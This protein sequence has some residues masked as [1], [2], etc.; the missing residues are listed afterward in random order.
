[1]V[2]RKYL[3]YLIL[4]K[5][6]FVHTKNRRIYSISPSLSQLS[7]FKIPENTLFMHAKHKNS[8]KN[9]S[10]SRNNLTLHEDPPDDNY[11]QNDNY[12][13]DNNDTHDDN[14]THDNNDA[15][16]NNADSNNDTYNNND[17]DDDKKE[18]DNTFINETQ[19]QRDEPENYNRSDE[20]EN[21]GDLKNTFVDDFNQN[22]DT[23]MKEDSR[24]NNSLANE[25]EP[26]KAQ[27]HPDDNK[28]IV[29]D[30]AKE[31][32]MK[33][34]NTDA[35]DMI[36]SAKQAKEH[37]DELL[38]QYKEGEFNTE[39]NKHT[40]PKD[41]AGN[42]IITNTTTT[43]MT[44]QEEKAD[45]LK[46][47]RDATISLYERARH[48]NLPVP[49]P[50]DLSSPEKI[51]TS[52]NA[53]E[54]II[55]GYRYTKIDV[56]DKTEQ[57]DSLNENSQ[58]AE[59]KEPEQMDESEVDLMEPD[60]FLQLKKSSDDDDEPDSEQNDDNEDDFHTTEYDNEMNESDNEMNGSDEESYESDNGMNESDEESY[61][62]ES[63]KSK[64]GTISAHEAMED[65]RAV[66]N[67]LS[68]VLEKVVQDNIGVRHV[69][70]KQIITSQY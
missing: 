6:V 2:K 65:L 54:Y 62:S 53:L 51:Y 48:K 32:Q 64:G 23:N 29:N 24:E 67:Q 35:G 56:N 8:I 49:D 28:E 43:P 33:N 13:H 4:L 34:M 19:N 12:T 9:S 58:P 55:D 52:L 3:L 37:A 59:T 10:R 1:M 61:E 11:Q 63:E 42:I 20:P 68:S 36:N 66:L 60:R 7:S 38:N 69:I 31:E 21:Q 15:Y 14:Y 44:K 39:T 47:I 30:I 26:E 27:E 17:V 70:T 57:S 18:Q 50:G 16:N 25:Y 41:D 45:P 5:C 22:V 40:L 46:S